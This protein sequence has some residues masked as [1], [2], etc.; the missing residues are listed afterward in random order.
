MTAGRELIRLAHRIL[1]CHKCS[2]RDTGTPVPSYGPVPADLV[3]LAEAPG[4]VEARSGMPLTGPAGQLLRQLMRRAGID[5]TACLMVNGISCSASSAPTHDQLSACSLHRHEAIA[6]AAP[7]I[8]VTVGKVAISALR[9]DLADIPMRE[10]AGQPFLWEK[11]HELDGRRN[12]WDHDTF[13][14]PTYHPSAALREKGSTYVRDRLFDDLLRVRRN[15]TDRAK[16]LA[17]WPDRCVKCTR[18]GDTF[19]GYLTMWCDDCYRRPYS[20]F[21]GVGTE[22]G[23]RVRRIARSRR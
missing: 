19:D 9:P 1:D 7:S 5:D 12:A 15:W 2:A 18:E 6:L 23:L 8:L 4:S 21:G 16:W 11:D 14:Y 13:V 10:L 17:D 22:R 20:L 3:I